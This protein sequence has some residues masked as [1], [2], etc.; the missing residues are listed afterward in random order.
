MLRVVLLLLVAG[1]APSV[2]AVSPGTVIVERWT[3][4]RV[5]ESVTLADAAC[6]SQGAGPAVMRRRDL[7]GSRWQDVYECR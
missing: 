1:C 5:Q 2:V 4:G 3:D 6:R 7:V